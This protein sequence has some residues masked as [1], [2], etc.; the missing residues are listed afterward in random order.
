MWEDSSVNIPVLTAYSM[1]PKSS[2]A[3]ITTLHHNI[4]AHSLFQCTEKN[5]QWVRTE[6][7]KLTHWQPFWKIS[8]CEYE[9]LKYKTVFWCLARKKKTGW[10]ERH[11]QDIYMDND[12]YVYHRGIRWHH[13]DTGTFWEDQH[14]HDIHTRNRFL[15]TKGL[16]KHKQP[17]ISVFEQSR[18]GQ[19]STTWSF[20]FHK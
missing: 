9:P 3:Y 19:W 18:Y 13:R 8:F 6:I 5:S 16:H 15:H 2:H 14:W 7:M 4:F 20:F 12:M 17:Q 10:K 11:V 1:K